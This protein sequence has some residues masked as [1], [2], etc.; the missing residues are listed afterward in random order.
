MGENRI[1]LR[2]L[3]LLEEQAWYRIFS[4]RVGLLEEGK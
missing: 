1:K 3:G 2:G 4:Y